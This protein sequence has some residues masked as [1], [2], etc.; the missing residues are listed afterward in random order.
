MIIDQLGL[1]RAD[2]S[3]PIV[4]VTED[5]SVIL[6]KDATTGKRVLD[7][8]KTGQAGLP[9]VVITK[10]DTGTSGDK[11]LTVT[12]EASDTLASGYEIVAT[13]PGIAWNT[14]D[15]LMV[16]RVHTQKKYL[17]SVI[18]LTGTTGTNTVDFLIVIGHALMGT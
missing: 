2:G 14:A 11:V 13:F 3:S 1:L 9:V 6:T 10:R 15:A 5:G 16:R 17:R 12:I 8:R 4:S 7:I 18:T